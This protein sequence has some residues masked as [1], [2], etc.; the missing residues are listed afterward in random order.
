[1]L[2]FA[3]LLLFVSS[4]ILLK[5]TSSKLGYR[6]SHV[7]AYI[8]SRVW[9]YT[10]IRFRLFGRFSVYGYCFDTLRRLASDGSLGT[11]GITE[12]VFSAAKLGYFERKRKESKKRI[13]HIQLLY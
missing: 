3:D 8:K 7:N 5:S 6:L 10:S 12:P 1:M 2:N 13:F 9:Y 11:E 4:Y